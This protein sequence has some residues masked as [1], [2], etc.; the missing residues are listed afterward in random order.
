MAFIGRSGALRKRWGSSNRL[1]KAYSKFPSLNGKFSDHTAQLL[2]WDGCQNDGNITKYIS[3]S[4]DQILGKSFSEGWCSPRIDHRAGDLRSWGCFMLHMHLETEQHFW[5]EIILLSNFWPGIEGTT[6]I[7]HITIQQSSQSCSLPFIKY[8]S[9]FKSL[10]I[11]YQTP[12]APGSVFP[13]CFE[14]SLTCKTC[15]VFWWTVPE[16]RVWPRNL[17]HKSK[18]H[19]FEKIIS[20]LQFFPL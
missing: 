19:I 3:A 12:A 9:A 2:V 6:D 13:R 16:C 1:S 11:S 15:P 8:Q 14:V 4:S 20:Q 7:W 17:H 5:W 10:I 18:L